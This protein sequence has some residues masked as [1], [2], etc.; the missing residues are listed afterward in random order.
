MYLEKLKTIL[1][2]PV[3]A[4]NSGSN[5]EWKDAEKKLGVEFPPDYK[6][7]ISTFG[8]GVIDD[9][10]W[11]YNPFT[12]NKNVNI[13]VQMKGNNAAYCTLKEEFP[14]DYP[15]SVFP[16]IGGLLPLGVTDNGDVLNWIT[17]P[18]K[19][20]ILVYGG[21]GNFEYQGTITEFIFDV[22]SQNINCIVFPDDFP[23]T[24]PKFI[25]LG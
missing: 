23:E 21:S 9:F 6:E 5:I 15:Y 17:T 13:F 11:I 14:D 10:L 1:S 4:V 20:T 2:P 22:L 19:W 25:S 7:F 24:N 18:G 3:K 16:E 8:T 12:D